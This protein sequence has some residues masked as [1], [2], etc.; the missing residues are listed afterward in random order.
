M[1]LLGY[2]ISFYEESFEEIRITPCKACCSGGRPK[3]SCSP[4]KQV[5]APVCKLA[6]PKVQGL[7]FGAPCILYG[8]VGCYRFIFGLQVFGP[9]CEACLMSFEDCMILAFN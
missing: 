1:G 9:Q 2:M 8:V 3:G 5:G 4:E 6:E 7:G